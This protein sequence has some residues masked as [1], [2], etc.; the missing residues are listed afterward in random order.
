MFCCL[1]YGSSVAPTYINEITPRRLRGTFGTTFQLGV[2][3]ILFLSQIITLEHILGGY[4]T[5]HYALGLT[6]VF[7]IA[8]VI[9]LCFVPESPKYLLLMKGDTNKAEK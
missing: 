3:V 8:Q 9:M 5:W 6:I 4:N 1:G 2:V 7:S